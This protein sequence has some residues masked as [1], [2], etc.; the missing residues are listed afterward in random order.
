MPALMIALEH[1]LQGSMVT[2]ITFFFALLK[3]HL[4]NALISA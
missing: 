4:I 1:I 3:S 2:Y